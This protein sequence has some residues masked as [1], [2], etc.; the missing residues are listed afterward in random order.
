[1]AFSIKAL[2]E[3]TGIQ[4]SNSRLFEEAFA[5]TS[6]MNEHRD[7]QLKNN[8][9]LEFLG[10]AVLQLAVS[11]YLFKHFPHVD[12]GDLTK[13]RI[14]I[15][16]EPSLAA[17]SRKLKFGRLVLLGKGEERGG[18]RERQA[19]LA[20]LFE[21]FVGA[22]Y[23]DAGMEAVQKF[24]QTHL[25]GQTMTEQKP[26]FIDYK[27]DLQVYVQNRLLG[28]LT[29]EITDERG[30]SHDREFAAHVL[31]AGVRYGV[32]VGR[33]KKEAE[34]A[35]ASQALMKLQTTNFDRNS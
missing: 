34:Q 14:S 17:A 5:H 32:G 19:L 7:R 35:A 4:C 18:G 28:T 16:C 26:V 2:Q 12:E 20:D 25:L 33:S 29:Y 11:D 31:I 21:A 3:L 8:E 22:L 13:M 27:S 30:P 6:Y 15:V 24:L 10:D 1:L 9:R 23:L